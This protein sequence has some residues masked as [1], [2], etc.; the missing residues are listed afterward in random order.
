VWDLIGKR[1]KIVNTRKINL[2]SCSGIRMDSVVSN[3]LWGTRLRE[4]EGFKLSK[5]VRMGL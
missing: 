5:I 1:Y 4:K 2:G 3:G